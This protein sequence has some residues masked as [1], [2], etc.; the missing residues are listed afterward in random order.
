MM[1][2]SE[3]L[4]H[5]D[6]SGVVSQWLMSTYPILG[7]RINRIL[8]IELLFTRQRGRYLDLALLGPARVGSPLLQCALK[9]FPEFRFPLLSD[10]IDALENERAQFDKVF[11]SWEL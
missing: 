1:N 11:K 4:T 10:V 3:P 9:L 2:K 8:A 6:I 5:R 7:D